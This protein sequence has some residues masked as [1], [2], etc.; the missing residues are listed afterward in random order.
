MIKKVQDLNV[1]TKIY[2][3]IFIAIIF[4]I[5]SGTFGNLNSTNMSGRAQKMYDDQVIPSQLLNKLTGMDQQIN[6]YI[7][8]VFFT[9]ES[10]EI[11]DKIKD[12]DQQ[13]MVLMEQY[14]KEITKSSKNNELI[15]S[16]KISG[17]KGIEIRNNIIQLK[18]EGKVNEAY[19]LYFGD[20]RNNQNES[21]EIIAQLF[22]LISESAKELNAENKEEGWRLLIILS[23]ISGTAI[24]VLSVIGY[25]F[26]NMITKPVKHMKELLELAEKGDL[27][28]DVHYQ[29]KDEIG[30]LMMSYSNMNH[31]IRTIINKVDRA[32]MNVAASAEELNAVADQ[33][34]SGSELTA[35]VTEQLSLG[36]SSQVELINQSSIN[37]KEMQELTTKMLNQ[38]EQVSKSS[39]RTTRL[40]LNGSSSIKNVIDQ[41][42]NIKK[43]VENLSTS[44]EGLN[45]HS[46]HIEKISGM[47]T[48]IA[49]Q[50]NLLSLN[51]AIEAARA[52]ES[53]KGFA[54]VAKEV[55]KLAEQSSNFANQINQI[56]HKLQRDIE[57][58]LS[59]MQL[60]IS[61]VAKGDIATKE[62][63][64][65]FEEIYNAIQLV[66]TSSEQAASTIYLVD[67]KTDEIQDVMKKVSEMANEAC[68]GSRQMAATTQEQLASSEEI[69]ASSQVL[70]KM[71][72]DLRELIVRFKV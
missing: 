50:T 69:A 49:D 35:R 28:G 1:S 5:L 25:I 58:V 23:I 14:Q 9:V 60:T 72:E 26:A 54:V 20:Y 21:K 12:A 43:D 10:E 45:D 37:L 39:D 64:S 33:S 57:M 66:V 18:R 47:I 44:I 62:A 63:E 19:Q 61:G 32:S 65:A 55:G 68:E 16:Y 70:A 17:E 38:T 52:G 46:S 4:L 31:S 22:T 8:D 56:V 29:T 71:S 24:I 11:E 6:E 40:S 36:S 48:S 30:K 13:K 34:K 59:S 51:A 67:K 7:L 41:M 53:G 27:T 3:L 42:G 2:F 15:Q